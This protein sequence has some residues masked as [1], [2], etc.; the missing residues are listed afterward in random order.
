VKE[1]L[2]PHEAAGV[3]L[4]RFLAGVLGVSRSELQRWIAA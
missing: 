1:L 3:R 4:D 2:V